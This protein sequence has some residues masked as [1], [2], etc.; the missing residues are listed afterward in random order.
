MPD[1]TFRSVAL[2][3]QVL[4][5]WLGELESRAS[6][7]EVFGLRGV[8]QID[9]EAGKQLVHVRLRLNGF[10]TDLALGLY[11]VNVLGALLGKHGTLVV[12]T[13]SGAAWNKSYADCRFASISDE[14]SIG[15]LP[16]DTTGTVRWFQE[17][18]L[19]FHKLSPP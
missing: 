4:R 5:C 1:L 14:D 3:G 7:S 8:S 13:N 12:Q 15:S 9:G 6:D 18:S 2:N 11:R 10:A 16:D 19:T 17:L